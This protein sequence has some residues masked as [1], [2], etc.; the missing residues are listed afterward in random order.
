MSRS[1]IEDADVRN[2]LIHRERHTWGAKTLTGTLTLTEEE[3]DVLDLDPGGASRNVVLPADA[4][5]LRGRV[6]YIYNSADAAENLVMKQSDGSTTVI[7]IGQGKAGIVWLS[8]NVSGTFLWRGLL[9][10]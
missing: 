4:V 9:G 10:S 5:G 2:P 1:M 6:F 7:T 3:A 8:G